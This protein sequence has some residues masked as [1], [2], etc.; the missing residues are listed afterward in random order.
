MN[1]AIEELANHFAGKMTT[2]ETVKSVKA[3]SVQRA[4]VRTPVAPIPCLALIN[5]AVTHVRNQLLVGPMP[6][7][8]YSTIKLNVPVK[9]HWL[10]MLL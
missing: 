5:N 9:S 6:F 4:V 1:A 3:K 10:E 7:A 2:A 8:A